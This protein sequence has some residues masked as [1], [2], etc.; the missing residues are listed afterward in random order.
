[1]TTIEC[2]WCTEPVGLEASSLSEIRC[3]GC[4]IAVEI[5]PDPP[6]APRRIDRA[7]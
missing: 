3:D 5:A 7:A 2:P 6:P 4:G 1:M